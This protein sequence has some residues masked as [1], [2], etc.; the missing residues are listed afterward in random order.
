MCWEW[1]DELMS[2]DSWRGGERGRGISHDNIKV[3]VY[4]VDKALMMI[5]LG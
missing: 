2:I 4:E 1:P 5:N 3:E